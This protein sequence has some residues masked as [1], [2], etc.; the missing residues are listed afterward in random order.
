MKAT[1][2]D[3]SLRDDV[4]E[5]CHRMHARGWVAN[6]DG[7]VTARLGTDRFLA[8]PTATSKAAVD[9]SN[10]LVVDGTGQRVSGTSRRFGEINLHLA[11]Y[12]GRDDVGAVVHAH[13]PYA[14]ALACS[15]SQLLARPFMPEAVVSIGATIPTV[16][17]AP[18]GADAAT[19]LAPF[20]RDV[21]A[22][23]LGN[24]GALAWGATVEQAYLR[25]ELVEHLARVATLAETTGGVTPLP[26]SAIPKLLEARANAGLGAA[27]E[28]AT[29]PSRSPSPAAS[30]VASL[31]REEILRALGRD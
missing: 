3:Q 29:Q 1:S 14:T 23:L 28:R 12:R 26:A 10:L 21:D 11:V 7:N 31:V 17:F 9:R 5:V 20:V 6:H 24:H 4:I 19:A 2:S 30:D 22:V 13:P 18:P 27:A 8:T 25:L 16:P 15:G